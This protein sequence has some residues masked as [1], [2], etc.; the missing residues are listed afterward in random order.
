MLLRQRQ[1]NLELEY[2]YKMKKKNC[3]LFVFM[4]IVACTSENANNCFQASGALIETV[5]PVSEFTTIQIEG[6]VTL[7][8]KQ[9]P[10]QEVLIE[11]G[12]N[13]LNDVYVGVD[14]ETLI[15]RDENN[16]NLVRDYEITTAYVTAPNIK[17]LRNSSSYDIISDGVLNY[18]E[19]YLASNTVG[20]IENVRKVGDFYLSLDCENLRVQANGQSVFYLSGTATTADINFSDEEPRFEGANLLV[21]DLV[22]FQRSANKMIVNPQN[23]ITGE[24]RGTGDIIAVNE[25][26]VVEVQQFFTGQLIFQD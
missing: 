25:P 3:Y 6:E 12:E 26:L 10:V 1:S 4:L 8:I 18:P 11:T 21:G 7:V 23:K 2:V 17:L 15:I 16:C 14:G 9:G 20:A 19:L 22:V 13:L 24:I 5:F